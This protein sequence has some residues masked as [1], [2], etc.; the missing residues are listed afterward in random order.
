[1]TLTV[2][3]F[4]ER[5]P[6]LWHMAELGSWP[7]IQQHGLLSTTA[8]LDLFEVAGEKRRKIES[9]R[10]PES[11][12]LDHSQWGRAVVRDQKPLNETLLLRRLDGMTA[13]EWYRML[14]ARVFFWVTEER[15]ERMLGAQAYRGRRHTVL[16]I[17]AH[18]MLS[19]YSG[20]ASISTINSGAIFP[21]SSTR[22]GAQTFQRF[23]QFGWVERSRRPEPVVEL[24]VDH[25]V[26]DVK[27]FVVGAEDRMA[28]TGPA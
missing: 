4:V 12:P 13:A 14:N 24:A 27:D 16:E 17:D 19:R 21:L 20:A 22:R 6:R 8:L 23:D 11:V 15:L 28:R 3:Q 5:Y 7:S 9:E 18:G 1:M 2:E 25:A 10:R 26:P